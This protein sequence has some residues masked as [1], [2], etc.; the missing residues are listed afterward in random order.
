M[1]CWRTAVEAAARGI[2]L[3]EKLSC[4]YKISGDP[5]SAR[6]FYPI[7]QL[8]CLPPLLFRNLLI[9]LYGYAA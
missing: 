9:P 4:A 8:V 2:E 3:S 1:S 5:P 7:T 6:A